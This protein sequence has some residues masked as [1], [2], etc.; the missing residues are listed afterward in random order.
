MEFLIL[1]GPPGS[2]KGTLSRLLESRNGWKPI[3]T[4]EEIRKRMSDPDSEIGCASTPYMDRGDYIPDALAL[5]L[6]FSIVENLSSEARIVL[7][8]FPRSVPQAE[9][10]ADWVKAQGHTVQGCVF[11]DL[12]PDRAAERMRNRRVCPTCRTTYPTVAGD[13]AGETCDACGGTLIP[14]EDDDP[15]RMARRVRR[16]EQ[17]TRPLRDWYRDRGRLIELDASKTTEQLREEIV[18]H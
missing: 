18:N 14:R 7:D 11:L 5:K 6:F 12:N 8:G 13:P 16:H 10:L 4:G 2:G 3:S 9:A 15:E 1:L 17:L